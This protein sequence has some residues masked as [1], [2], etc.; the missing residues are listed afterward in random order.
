MGQGPEQCYFLGNDIRKLLETLVQIDQE[1]KI[2]SGSM[3]M[4]TARGGYS[5]FPLWF[6]VL[7]A[8]MFVSYNM[9]EKIT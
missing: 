1:D 9:V 4:F 8:I 7:E 5:C 3:H 6:I 2:F